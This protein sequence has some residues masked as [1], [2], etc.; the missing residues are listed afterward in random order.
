MV[1]SLSDHTGYWMRM[2]SN[3]VSQDF[4]RR[5]AGEDVTVAEWALMRILLDLE[6]TSPSALSATMGMTKGAVSKLADRL[7]AKGLIAR[8]DNPQ[9][10][11]AHTLSLTAKGRTT[12]PVLA[13]LADS[14]DAA[15]FS[16]LGTEELQNLQ[17]L[18]KTLVER[19]GLKIMPVD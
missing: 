5:L 17:H 4:A 6:P 3:A 11:R 9:D 12:V 10:K 8:Q 13:A 18:L 14:N 19:R 15:F 7:E 1:S 2:V 16:V